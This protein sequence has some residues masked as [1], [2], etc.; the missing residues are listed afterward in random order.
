MTYISLKCFSG[1]KMCAWESNNANSP[2]SCFL[3]TSH[4]DTSLMPVCAM[5]PGVGTKRPDWFSLKN[6]LNFIFR[7]SCKQLWTSDCHKGYI[8]K[9]EFKSFIQGVAEVNFYIFPLFFLGG[10]WEFF[11]LHSIT[12]SQRLPDS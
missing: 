7:V 2:S 10:I 4:L 5:V 8:L 9:M 6:S 3:L 11:V 1:A 12:Q